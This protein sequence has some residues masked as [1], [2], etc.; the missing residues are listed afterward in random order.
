MAPWILVMLEKWVEC[1]GCPLIHMV[2]IRMWWSVWDW[3]G[4]GRMRKRICQWEKL[5]RKKTV[6]GNRTSFHYWRKDIT[7]TCIETLEHPWAGEPTLLTDE[8]SRSGKESLSL[9]QI[10][11][12]SILM[13]FWGY[14]E[15]R[16]YL[17]FPLCWQPKARRSQTQ[18]GGQCGPCGWCTLSR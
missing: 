7:F 9:L 10:I 12:K 15:Q 3:V 11:S 1:A 4:V 2:R 5:S 17:L 14:A 16:S 8:G 18:K 13:S 6:P